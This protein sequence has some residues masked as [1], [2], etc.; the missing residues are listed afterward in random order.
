[1]AITVFQNPRSSSIPAREMIRGETGVRPG[2][3]PQIHANTAAFA[4]TQVEI[5]HAMDQL[6][7][8]DPK[9]ATPFQCIS[10]HSLRNRRRQREHCAQQQ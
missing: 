4:G 2:A 5:Q 1:M 9:H 8:T 10:D 3:K 6:A 7:V